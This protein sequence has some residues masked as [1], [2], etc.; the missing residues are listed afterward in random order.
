MQFIT[1]SLG[2]FLVTMC[3]HFVRNLQIHVLVISF[4]FFSLAGVFSST[5][6]FSLQCHYRDNC[7][8]M[9]SCNRTNVTCE[10]PCYSAW[11]NDSG[12]P[13]VQFQ[14]CWFRGKRDDCPWTSCQ[15]GVETGRE[16]LYFCCCNSNFC[17]AV[18]KIGLKM[19]EIYSTR[20]P[21]TSTS[22]LVIKMRTIMLQL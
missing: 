19:P 8:D 17:N 15:Y 16:G 2:A 21:S 3:V 5:H 4:L 20:Q 7:K 12:T 14:G 9:Q 10:T 13:E 1:F 11:R 18:D 22:K 6:T